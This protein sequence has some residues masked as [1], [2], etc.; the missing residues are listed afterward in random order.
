MNRGNMFRGLANVAGA[1][2]LA[3]ALVTSVPG[4]AAAQSLPVAPTAL[5]ATPGAGSVSLTWTAPAAG[6]APVS[7]YLV[8]RSSNGGQSY[9]QVN[10]PVST[11]RSAVVDGLLGGVEYRFRVRAVNA[12]GPGTYSAHAVATPTIGVPGRPLDVV[13]T[14]EAGAVAL[15]WSVPAS[16]GGS[17]ITDYAIFRSSNGG[18]SFARVTDP[19]STSRSVTVRGLTGGVRYHFRIRAINAAGMGNNSPV[20]AASPLPSAP[21]APLSVAAVPGQGMVTLSWSPPTTDGGSPVTDYWIYRSSNGGVSYSLV[22]DGVS[23]SLVHLQTGLPLGSEQRFRVRAVNA[24][25]AGPFTTAIRTTVPSAPPLLGMPQNVVV[26]APARTSTLD[27]SWEYSTSEPEADWF[28]VS[29]APAGTATPVWTSVH[30]EPGTSRRAIVAGLTPGQSY[31]VAVRAG[32]ASAEGELSSASAPATVGTEPTP[33]PPTGVTIAP[34]PTVS[35][36]AIVSTAPAA[37]GLRL[38]VSGTLDGD[39]KESIYAVG[40]P[41]ATTVAAQV[42]VLGDWTIEVRW[43]TET[44]LSSA[45]A[46]P[47]ELPEGV[48]GPPPAP[49]EVRVDPVTLPEEGGVVVDV[50]SWTPAQRDGVLIDARVR[51]RTA[52]NG[53]EWVEFDAPARITES[54]RNS[55]FVPKQDRGSFGAALEYEVVS[56]DGMASEPAGSGEE[57]AGIAFVPL[58]PPPAPWLL[59]LVAAAMTVAVAGRCLQANRPGVD[60][61]ALRRPVAIAIVASA[62]AASVPLGV[63]EASANPISRPRIHGGEPARSPMSSVVYIFTEEDGRPNEFCE[64]RKVASRW[65]LTAAHCVDQFSSAAIVKVFAGSSFLFLKDDQGNFLRTADGDPIPAPGTRVYESRRGRPFRI[66]EGYI[67]GDGSLGRTPDLALIET[68]EPIFAGTA[69]LVDPL[70]GSSRHPFEEAGRMA[71]FLGRGAGSPVVEVP[72]TTPTRLS[73]AL[74]EVTLQIRKGDGCAGVSDAH[75]CAY[76]GRSSLDGPDKGDSGGGVMAVDRGS[77]VVIGVVSGTSVRDLNGLPVLEDN[78][79]VA[80]WTRVAPYRSW[81]DRVVAPRRYS[82]VEN[83]LVPVPDPAGGGGGLLRPVS[84][85]LVGVGGRCEASRSGYADAVAAD[86]AVAHF[87]LGDLSEDPEGLATTDTMRCVPAEL[88]TPAPQAMLGVAEG[89]VGTAMSSPDGVTGPFKVVD[90]EVAMLEPSRRSVEFW[91]QGRGNT[92]DQ[93]VWVTA[94]GIEAHVSSYHDVVAV[95]TPA[96]GFRF[97]DA[98]V[99]FDGG[100]H[101]VVVTYSGS[102]DVPVAAFVDGVPLTLSEQLPQAAVPSASTGAFFAQVA[103]WRSGGGSAVA[104]DEVVLYDRVLS[105]DEAAEHWAYARGLVPCAAGPGP[106]GAVGFFIFGDRSVDATTPVARNSVDSCRSGMYGRA[107]ES[108]E[109]PNGGAAVSSPVGGWGAFNVFRSPVAPLAVEDRSV[110]FWVQGRGNTEDQGVWV[111]GPGIE[112][113]VTSFHDVV[114]VSTPTSGFRF[115]DSGVTF[116]GGWHHVLVT[117]GAGAQPSVRA[118]VDGVPL[119][120]T[121]SLPDFT[122]PAASSGALVAQVAN[123]RTAPGSAV[124][125]D[126]VVFYGRELS[127]STARL[128]WGLA[129]GWTCVSLPASP[130]APAARYDFAELSR[131]SPPFAFD[132]SGRCHNGS[133]PHNPSVTR[134]TRPQGGSAVSSPPGVHGAITVVR[135]GVGGLSGAQRSIEF[136][137]QGRGNTEDQ[138]VWVTGP[139]IEVHVGSFHDVVAVSTPTGGFRFGDSGVTFDGGWHRVVVTYSAGAQSTV[140]AFVD[141]VELSVTETLPDVTV[142]SASSGALLVQVANWRSTPGSAVGVDGVAVYDIVL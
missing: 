116:D 127:F 22:D 102:G 70:S 90:T 134:T 92:D 49:T 124:A 10:E 139:G 141:G 40:D 63:A 7:D 61:R 120:L 4:V 76:G 112:V 111:T 78:R 128:R 81:I 121:E 129:S 44:G 13:A 39:D 117:Y 77:E 29:V 72:G 33:P 59:L 98:G 37:G 31:V 73:A 126:D 30:S 36:G 140:R 109:R 47:F 12:V 43:S 20:V 99:T 5:A 80:A 91:V 52:G 136:W 142:P 35:G 68:T 25:G 137:V 125:I 57:G 95:S 46:G 38:T 50:V 64:G 45:P 103:N 135:A 88:G 97:G 2:V 24:L 67:P 51:V 41:G 26:S 62:L 58:G 114:A 60:R 53:E 110:E 84:E 19:V 54:G 94:P 119:S 132:S 130:L 71:R 16:H 93:G 86:G 27:V 101:H 133:Y 107:L 105:A 15:R 104:I 89:A 21:G 69:R 56:Y 1:V 113:H 66:I 48:L 14:P 82:G 34:D 87:D 11:A 122:V 96:G 9:A 100:W 115:G 74:H 123:W 75:G 3:S 17:P 18:T 55:W 106:D 28:D 42:P 138:G 65:V 32:N 85:T 131:A 108:T 79:R 6:G 8:F 23:T 118:Y 83:A